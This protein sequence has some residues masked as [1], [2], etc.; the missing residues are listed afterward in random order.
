VKIAGGSRNC[1]EFAVALER[2]RPEVNWR[3]IDKF[4]A[5]HLEIGPEK[6]SADLETLHDPR[7][8]AGISAIDDESRRRICA[9][10][11]EILQIEGNASV[12][13]QEIGDFRA[14]SLQNV[15]EN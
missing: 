13:Q 12:L 5:L 7:P 10:E 1:L 4:W 2:G 6:F 3:N 14:M 11:D 15:A 9:V 8:H